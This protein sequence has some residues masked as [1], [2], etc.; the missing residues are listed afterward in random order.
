MP[1][2][3]PE[4]NGRIKDYIALIGQGAES[5]I[6]SLKVE[7]FAKEQRQN[8]VDFITD[9]GKTV[10]RIDK[11]HI[12]QQNKDERIL[13]DLVDDIEASFSELEMTEKQESRLRSILEQSAQQTHALH[14]TGLTIDSEFKL[15]LDDINSIIEESHT[16]YQDIVLE[17]DE[18]E[19]VEEYKCDYD[20]TV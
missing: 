18:V 10:N 1:V 6:K 5:K 19:E 11:A 4:L 3:N 13:S 20:E 8:L 9:L 16:Q 12:E 14:D 2:E 17:P 7:L 15:I